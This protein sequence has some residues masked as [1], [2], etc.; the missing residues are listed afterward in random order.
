LTPLD[1][2]FV[3]E[4]SAAI[5]HSYIETAGG[6][7][8]GMFRLAPES[9]WSVQD[10]VFPHLMPGES[11]ESIVVSEP[12]FFDLPRGVMTWHVKLRT[13]PYQTDVVGIRFRASDVQ[14]W[15]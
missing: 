9:E 7:R 4:S 11:A 14:D 10:Q 5:D 6:P 12:V 3:R 1:P 2:D 15:R 8:I 13:R